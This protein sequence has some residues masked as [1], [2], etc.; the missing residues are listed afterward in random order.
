MNGQRLALAKQTPCPRRRQ[1]AWACASAPD[2][3]PA[4]VRSRTLPPCNAA[5]SGWRP[6]GRTARSRPGW[7]AGN[8]GSEPPARA[9]AG[10]LPGAGRR[11]GRGK[12]RR[13]ARSVPSRT[14]FL[15]RRGRRTAPSRPR[16][17]GRSGPSIGAAPETTPAAAAGSGGERPDERHVEWKMFEKRRVLGHADP[18]MQRGPS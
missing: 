17:P 13:P 9:A 3:A 5:A 1:A 15:P 7:A 11:R 16:G 14:G 12:A 8:R 18:H 2:A 6:H 4:L 10:A